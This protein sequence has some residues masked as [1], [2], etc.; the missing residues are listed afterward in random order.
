M[1]QHM[2]EDLELLK[3]LFHLYDK[4]GLDGV[5]EYLVKIQ[6]DRNDNVLEP[7]WVLTINPPL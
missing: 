2:D 4:K 3:K 6:K 7:P 1:S 5:E